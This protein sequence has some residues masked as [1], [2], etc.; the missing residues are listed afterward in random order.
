MTTF[1]SLVLVSCKAFA[2][3]AASCILSGCDEQD[4]VC[5]AGEARCAPEGETVEVCDP[6][7]RWERLYDCQEYDVECRQCPDGPTCGSCD[8]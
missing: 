4:A 7:G 2:P 6:E 3:A 5:K 1:L 8:G